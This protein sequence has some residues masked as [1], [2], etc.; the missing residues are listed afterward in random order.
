MKLF[1]INKK[2][3]EIEQKIFDYS[4]WDN[5]TITELGD[6]Y[7][8]IIRL[9]NT[10]LT[11]DLM[12]CCREDIDATRFRI[13]EDVLNLK[14]IIKEKSKINCEADIMQMEELWNRFAG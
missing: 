11:L 9:R 8:S 2:L 7:C 1:N 10:F 6:I 13:L 5:L 4:L 12:E 3:E 14:I